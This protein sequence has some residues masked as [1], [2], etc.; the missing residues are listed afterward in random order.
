[1]RGPS[2]L[3]R[4]L[5]MWRRRPGLMLLG[6]LPAL[7]V[8]GAVLAALVALLL[9]VGDLVAWA[10]PF[11][12]DWAE[13]LRGLLRVGL[14]V[15]VVLGF[16]VVSSLTFTAVTLTVGDPFYERIWAETE[17]MLG[18]EVPD[19]GPGFWKSA[20]DGAALAGTG[21]LLGVGVFVLGLLPVIGAV[22]GLVLGVAVSGRLL[23]A[24][25]VSR[26]LEAR[27]MDRVA[28][29]EVLRRD[30]GAVLGFGVATQLCFL[31]PLGAVAVMPAAVVGATMLARD[32]LEREAS[33][34]VIRPTAGDVPPV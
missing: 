18:G 5:G 6:M 33:G 32:L 22:V 8:L 11:A 21:L 2:Y 1:M 30:R 15:L 13:T 10:T 26:A 29:A 31:V 19:Q 24:E 14:A 3:L 27:G 25:L 16:V 7:L 20:K 9:H 28:R 34:D 23:A 12:D 4:G 17:R